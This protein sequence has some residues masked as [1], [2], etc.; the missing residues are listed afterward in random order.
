MALESCRAGTHIYVSLE[1]RTNRDLRRPTPFLTNQGTPGW[2]D[3]SLARGW[4]AGSVRT[5]C[6][7]SKKCC[8]NAIRTADSG[9]YD[10]A[11]ANLRRTAS[12]LQTMATAQA[13]V[14]ART[15]NSFPSV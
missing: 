10:H 15:R 13:K 11:P 12:A 8:E 9:D 7:K 1:T 5:E 4:M 3:V 2:A 6:G 14:T